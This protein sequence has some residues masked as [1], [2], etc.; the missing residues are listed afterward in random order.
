[1]PQDRNL[2]AYIAIIVLVGLVFWYFKSTILLVFLAILLA[3]TMYLPTSALLRRGWYPVLA[4]PTGIL[5]CLLV[6]VVIFGVIIPA[7]VT[8]VAQIAETYPNALETAQGYYESLRANL[9]FLPDLNTLFE[10]DDGAFGQSVME[11]VSGALGGLAGALG[12]TL[13]LFVV[14]IFL[15]ISP[16]DYRTLVLRMFPKS[17]SKRTHELLDLIH[18]GL[19]AWLKTLG[20][21]ISVTFALVF[22]SFW[23]IGFPHFF[24]IAVITA[25]ATFIPTI[26]AIIP[27]IPIVLFG[28]TATNPWIILVALGV[29]VLIQQLESNVITPSF[30]KAELNILPAGVLL[31]QIVAGQI[32]GVVG[33]LISVPILVVCV[34][35]I[36]EL[37]SK[38]IMGWGE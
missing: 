16:M 31:F 4:Y 11:T 33:I 38:D 10:S 6:I 30:Q 29:Y 28:L 7:L 18:A 25:V 35:L 34:T 3:L 21:S 32:F 13:V 22:V 26:G 15:L 2:L 14:S 27:V 1:M 12:Q 8:A 23:A 37:Y 17:A 5:V 36:R 19:N 20:M 24:E 9:S